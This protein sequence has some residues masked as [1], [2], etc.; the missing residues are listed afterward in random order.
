VASPA[1]QPLLPQD[2][3]AVKVARTVTEAG[4]VRKF[5]LELPSL[6]ALK[7]IEGILSGPGKVMLKDRDLYGLGSF[8]L[9]KRQQEVVVGMAGTTAIPEGASLRLLDAG[10]KPFP[11]IGGSFLSK[12]NHQYH[13]E[14]P[15]RVEDNAL[16][17]ASLEVLVLK[18]SV[19]VPFELSDIEV[20]AF[21]P[22]RVFRSS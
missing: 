1:A 5:L 7:M 13:K 6:V 8:T 11:C 19:K 16:A 21:P 3:V 20:S 22:K 12:Q 10:G 9:E 18:N 14:K 2:V 4:L 17:E 15:Y